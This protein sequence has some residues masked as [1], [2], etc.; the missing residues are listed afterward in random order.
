ML[1]DHLPRPGRKRP[2]SGQGRSGSQSL[3]PRQARGQQGG[4]CA[5][6]EVEWGKEVLSQPDSH[7]SEAVQAFHSV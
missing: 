6:C 4:E 1:S 3:G 2:G 5:A 7:L